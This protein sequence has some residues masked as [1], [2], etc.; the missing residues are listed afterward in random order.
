MLENFDMT[1]IWLTFK[2]A[3][4]TL[5]ILMLIS[6]P[7]SWWLANSSSRLRV[8]VE[9]I[10]SLPLILP[11]TVLGFYLLILFNPSGFFGSFWLKVTGTSLAFSFHGLVLASV[12]YSLPFVV[13]PIQSAFETI[14][15][16]PIETSYNLGAKPIDTFVNIV[17][18]LAKR[19]YLTAGVLGFAHTLGEFGVVLMIGGSIPGET[20]VISIVI[21]EQVEILNYTSAHVYSITLISISMILLIIVYSVNKNFRFKLGSRVVQ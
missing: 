19:G 7:L 12:I 16:K 21:F 1:P 9:S 13:Q 17:L 20:K 10:V 11:P 3:F 8:F 15:K 14:G 2:L 6:T 5:I 18:P 4:V